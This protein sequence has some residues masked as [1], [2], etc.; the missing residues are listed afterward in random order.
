MRSAVAAPSGRDAGE[1][2]AAVEYRQSVFATRRAP[3]TPND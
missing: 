1:I 3:G 2:T